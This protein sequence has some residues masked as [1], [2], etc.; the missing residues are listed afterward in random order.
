MNRGSEYKILFLI[1]FHESKE[2]L[3]DMIANIKKF[4]SKYPVGIIVSNGTDID[5]SDIETKDIFVIKRGIETARNFPTLVPIHIEMWDYVV[6]NDI[7]CEYV[8]LLASNQLFINHN[9]YDLIKD[10]DSSYYDRGRN[11]DLSFWKGSSVFSEYCTKIGEEN[12]KY[13]SNHDG[14][15]FKTN[16]FD[17]MMNYFCEYR[18]LCEPNHQEEFLYA[19][20]VSKFHCPKL[21]SFSE[22]NYF[23]ADICG[24]NLYFSHLDIEKVN[25]AKEKNMFLVKR[26]DRNINDETRVYIRNLS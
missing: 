7:M 17:D 6:D 2:C 24:K 26:I 16:I 20:Y 10:F 9:V 23:S 19:S 1:T 3:Q 25:C 18:G 13:Q 15:F 22:Y 5:I 11:E 12:I 4:N 8:M 14:M 21:L